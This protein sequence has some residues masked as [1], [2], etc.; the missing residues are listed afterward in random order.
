MSRLTRIPSNSDLIALWERGTGEHPVDRALML[1]V[2][3]SPAETQDDLARLSIGARDARQLRA[4][5]IAVEGDQPD[6]RC[7]ADNLNLTGG[8]WRIKG[9]DRVV[10]AGGAI[11][12]S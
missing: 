8:N 1:L 3:C 5:T 9:E 2:A 11:L 12:Y 7:T 4:E 6:G 10:S